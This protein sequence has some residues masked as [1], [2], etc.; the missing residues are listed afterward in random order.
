M[1]F[2]LIKDVKRLFLRLLILIPWLLLSDHLYAE[3]S[4]SKLLVLGDSLSAGYGMRQEQSWVSL[5]QNAW[6]DKDIIVVNAAIS[7]ETTVGGLARLPRLLELHKPSHLLIELGGNDGLQGHQ[8]NKMKANISQMI[9]MAQQMDIEVILQQMRIPTNY[10]R[11]Y[12]EMF[13]G[14]YQQ[15]AEQYSIPMI[16]FF[17]Q[18]VA[19]EPK[20]MQRDGIHPTAEAQPIIMQYMAKH[21]APF[22]HIESANSSDMN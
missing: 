22:F 2:L 14:M 18:E 20:M 5:L 9:E 7:G 1:H 13:T 8:V 15:L 3:Q 16:D 11:R 19:L 10:G 21:L 4:Q 17:I 6:Q 12:N